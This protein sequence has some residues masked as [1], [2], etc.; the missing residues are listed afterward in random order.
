MFDTLHPVTLTKKAAEEV[1]KIM[2]TKNIP[3]G[4]GLRVGMKG[5][6]CSGASLIIGFD[7]KKST[8]LAYEVETIPVYVDKKHVMYV[9]GKEVDF[10]EG[11]D[12]RGFMFV[13]KGSGPLPEN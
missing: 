2:Q 4:Y 6:G 3:A 12:A 9:V 11:D 13:E 10:Y 8:D 5:G 1:R 7:T